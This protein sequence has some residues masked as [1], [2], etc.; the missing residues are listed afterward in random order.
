MKKKERMKIM[1]L[2]KLFDIVAT[3]IFNLGP[4]DFSL[5]RF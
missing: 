1:E 3:D 2:L 4:R 5:P